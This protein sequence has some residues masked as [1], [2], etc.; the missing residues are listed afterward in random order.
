[1][2]DPDIST[3]DALRLLSSTDSIPTRRRPADGL[4]PSRLPAS[5][6]H[7]RRRR[8][9]GGHLGQ[10][11]IPGEVHEAFAGP[12]IGANDGILITIMMYGGNDGLNTVVPYGNGAVLPAA[13][14]HRRAAE[15][16]AG[17]QQRHRAA[18]QPALPAS[19][20]GNGQVA[21]VQ[22]VGYPD[23]DLSHFTSMAIW[24]NAKFGPG[25]ATSGWIG[26]WLDGQS[27]AVAELGAATID[28]SVPLH[29]HGR[30][31]SRGRHLAV[32]RH[33]R[34]RDRAA[35]S[36]HV[37][38]HQGDGRRRRPGAGSGTTCSPRPCAH[39]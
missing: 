3:A 30:H 11:L 9:A 24:M 8:R 20:F 17:D 39:S 33:V 15:P 36:A 37:R 18:P 38:R 31:P 25:P 27:A 4:D 28:S 19:L 34:R 29:L 26:R 2:L 6:R 14:E 12:P 23:P 22:G 5:R 32:G 10:S 35:R 16:G 21:I 7:G 13:R 1:M